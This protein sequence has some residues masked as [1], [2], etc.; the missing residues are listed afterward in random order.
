MKILLVAMLFGT[1][2]FGFQFNEEKFTKLNDC[3][4]GYQKVDKAWVVRGWCRKVDQIKPALI[5]LNKQL[6]TTSDLK[7]SK[8]PQHRGWYF[9]SEILIK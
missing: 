1:I 7:Y 6:K 3:D 4:I 5:L 9:Q 8:M 2:A